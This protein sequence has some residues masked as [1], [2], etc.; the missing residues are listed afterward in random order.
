M[1]WCDQV[2]ECNAIQW[3]TAR[4]QMNATCALYRYT[5]G[6]RVGDAMDTV[7]EE[8]PDGQM[9]SAETVVLE[10]GDP[11]DTHRSDVTK[12]ELK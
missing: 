9:D 12:Y 3:T 7:I 10:Y 2:N 5:D 11:A 1:D 4:K 8:L 6:G